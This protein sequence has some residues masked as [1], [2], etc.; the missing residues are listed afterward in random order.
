[1]NPCGADQEGAESYTGSEPLDPALADRFSLII[2]SGDWS[3]LGP[4]AQ[5]AITAPVGEGLVTAA[6]EALRRDVAAWRERFL[7]QLPNCPAR[8]IEYVTTAVT[9]LNGAA[10]RISPRRARLIARTLLAVTIVA[11]RH[12]EDDYRATLEASLPQPAFG[13]QVAG[14]VVA[15]AHRAAWDCSQA[16]AG[17]WIH[18]FLLAPT[19]VE[20]L[21]ILIDTHPTPDEGSQAIAQLIAQATPERSA[22]FAFATYPAA[23][24][25]HLPIGAEGVHD[26]AKVARPL[27]DAKGTVGVR[28]GNKDWATS[29]VAKQ[30]G[31]RI[32]GLKGKRRERATQFFTACLIHNTRIADP[33]ALEVEIN[34]CV[35]LLGGRN[36]RAGAAA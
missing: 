13:Q 7:A 17:S 16:A 2:E 34:A 30:L 12:A 20:H 33:Q 3:S 23:A 10:V 36:G 6:N 11:G 14:A 26:L 9:A 8:I 35:E 29:E 27:L 24:A 1:M 25:G 22:A 21:Q 5:R 28:T 31:T 18:R 19:L 15:A 4:D 32:A